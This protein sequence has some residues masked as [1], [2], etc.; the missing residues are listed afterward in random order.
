[1]PKSEGVSDRILII[2]D[3]GKSARAM[4]RL[5]ESAQLGDNV[6]A[7]LARLRDGADA[8]RRIV[9]RIA[10]VEAG[11]RGEALS[12][13]LILAGLRRM[14]A[15]VEQEVRKVPILN[16]ILDHE[17]LG[18]EFKHGLQQG[19]Q[20][21]VQQGL[22]QGLQQGVQQGAQQEA[23]AMLH[24]LLEGRFGVLP[25][26]VEQKLANRSVAEL[27]KISVRVLNARSIEELFF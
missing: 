16:D 7:I 26:W 3:E 10:A 9:A 6:I 12:Q 14:A 27:E 11:Q 21:G 17:V 15:V 13:L 19:L 2:G 24:G 23:L 5:L 22:Q 4:G 8:V 1:M 25:A 20:Q 18:R